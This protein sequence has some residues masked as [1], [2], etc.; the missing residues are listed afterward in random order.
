MEK[1]DQDSISQADDILVVDGSITSLQLLT[2]ILTKE[3]YL[4][5]P[6]GKAAFG[7]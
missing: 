2:E 4:G 6:R 5:A 3:G 7:H 1:S